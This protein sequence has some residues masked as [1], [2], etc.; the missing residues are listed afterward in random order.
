MSGDGTVG[1]YE[2]EPVPGLPEELPEDEHVL[3]RGAPSWRALA[4]RAFHVRK[5]AVYFGLLV[6]WRAASAVSAG[7]GALQAALGIAGLLA[8]GGGAVGVLLGLAW[9]NAR[10]T[11]YTITDRRVVLRFGVALPMAVNLPFSSVQSADL[12]RFADG[13]GD[14]PLE[15]TGAERIGYV[16]MWPHA[17]PWRFGRGVAPM[18]RAVPDARGVAA[19]LAGALAASAGR[20]APTV[21]AGRPRRVRATGIP[22]AVS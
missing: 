4:R 15:V 3:W 2:H 18:L 7:E 16:M 6:A 21:A 19:T 10:A 9:L 14:I 13:T 1:E 22:A 20:A 12:R 17:R 8:L 11:V 5:V